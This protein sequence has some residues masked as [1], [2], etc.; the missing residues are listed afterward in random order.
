MSYTGQYAVTIN[1]TAWTAY[2]INVSL[3]VGRQQFTDRWVPDTAVI[4]LLAPANSGPAIP[5]L[6]D[7]IYFDYQVS[8]P[9]L[10]RGVIVDIERSYGIPYASATG[11]APADRLTIRAQ[12]EATN[13]PAR[14]IATAVTISTNAD[15]STAISDVWFAAINA[16]SAPGIDGPGAAFIAQ[17]ETYTGN[18]LDYV[19][20]CM[21]SC[22]GYLYDNGSV[23]LKSNG[24]RSG[25]NIINF[26]DT[27][28]QS[29]STHTYFYDAIDFLATVDNSYTRVRVGY[30]NGSATATAST[31]T[32][33]YTAY[34]TTSNLKNLSEAQ[35]VADV[36]LAIL[37]QSAYRP[38]RISTKASIVGSFDLATQLRQNPVGTRVAITFRGTTYQMICEGYSCSQDLNDA[39]WTFYFSPALAQP[40]ILDS[41]TFG[42]LDTNTLGIG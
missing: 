38:F 25:T 28:S 35:Q 16:L 39:R 3:T 2:V 34:Q 9:S 10:F 27:G 11:Y 37:S 26:T 14:A 19:N 24:Y 29:S 1:G 22:A 33:P 41:T 18:V 40:L 21:I 42:I 31:G 5:S 20:S 30:N 13:E 7:Q 36:D 15:L 12:A 4:E 6:G 32:I 8:P 23:N 17:S